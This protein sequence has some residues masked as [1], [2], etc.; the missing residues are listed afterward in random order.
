[1]LHTEIMAVFV[2]IKQ[3][4]QMDCVDNIK[5]YLLLNPA[6]N[7]LTTKPQMPDQIRDTIT[8]VV[9]VETWPN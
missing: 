8:N 3:T 9:T 2:R 1:M 7:K 5:E 6:V 4:M